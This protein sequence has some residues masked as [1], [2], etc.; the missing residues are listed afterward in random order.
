MMSSMLTLY[1]SV[2]KYLKNLK[3]SKRKQIRK[4]DL[5]NQQGWK[6]IG[7]FN[8]NYEHGFPDQLYPQASK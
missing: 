2:F 8:L 4:F 5:S 7:M 1:S 6:P 3:N